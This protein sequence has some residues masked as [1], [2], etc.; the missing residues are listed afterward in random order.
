MEIL[1]DFYFIGKLEMSLKVL[2]LSF[3]EN[4]DFCCDRPDLRQSDFFLFLS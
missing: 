2:T 4:Y 1:R 3:Q